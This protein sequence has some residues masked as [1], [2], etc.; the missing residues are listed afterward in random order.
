MR[1]PRL[2]CGD[3]DTDS[4]FEYVIVEQIATGTECDNFSLLV[5]E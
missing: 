4:D 3:Y 5:L 1:L 2:F